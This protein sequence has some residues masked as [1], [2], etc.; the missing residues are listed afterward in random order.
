M[1]SFESDASSYNKGYYNTS[2]IGNALNEIFRALGRLFYIAIRILLILF[3]VSFVL[4][5]SLLSLSF[6]MLLV[7]K[8][9]VSISNNSVDMNLIYLS[10]FLNYVVNPVLVPWVIGLTLAI[11]IIPMLALDLLGGKDDFLVQG[12][13]WSFQPCGSGV[14]GN[15]YSYSGGDP[16]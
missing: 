13:R 14:V 3:G 2:R 10:D 1:G 11:L 8:Y 12:K 5:G 6:V 7:F 16:L 15:A 9:P 4:L